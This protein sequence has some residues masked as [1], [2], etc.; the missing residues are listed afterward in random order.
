M[1]HPDEKYFM[2]RDHV[3][4]LLE[5]R[6]GMTLVDVDQYCEMLADKD[7][8]IYH[9]WFAAGLEPLLAADVIRARR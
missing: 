4:D 7:E 2:W 1:G 9:E 8:K 3:D 5:E 6:A